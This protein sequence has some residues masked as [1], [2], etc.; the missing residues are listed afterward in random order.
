MTVADKNIVY[1]NLNIEYWKGSPYVKL[2]ATKTT[3]WKAS[4]KKIRSQCSMKNVIDTPTC[5]SS[6]EWAFTNKHGD[7]S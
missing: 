5:Q 3:T 4:N 1:Y 6:S 2:E 7:V